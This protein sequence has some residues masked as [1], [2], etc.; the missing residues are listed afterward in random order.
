MCTTSD[1]AV[2]VDYDNYFN[3]QASSCAAECKSALIAKIQSNIEFCTAKCRA[4]VSYSKLCTKC[5]T[6]FLSCQSQNCNLCFVNGAPFVAQAC[7]TCATNT[8]RAQLAECGGFPDT[9]LSIPT[10]APIDYEGIAQAAENANQISI[11]VGATVGGAAFLLAVVLLVRRR[12]LNKRAEQEKDEVANKIFK[13][14][15]VFAMTAAG[16]SVMDDGT[17]NPVFSQAGA[18]VEMRVP[19][20][21]RYSFHGDEIDELDVKAGV[22]LLGISRNEQWWVALDESTSRVGVIPASY[23]AEV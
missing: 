5:F 13:N 18:Q 19:L 16:V 21:T 20:R 22:A 23:V 6:N 2:F 8:C 17:G 12:S 4:F 9:V 3:Y 14:K 7:K 1:K 11:I 10:S 15:D